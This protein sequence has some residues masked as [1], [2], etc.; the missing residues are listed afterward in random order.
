MDMTVIFF[1]KLLGSWSS[2][3]IYCYTESV[4]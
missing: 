4:S 2:F 3:S 1:V